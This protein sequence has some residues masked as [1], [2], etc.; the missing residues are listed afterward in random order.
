MHQL[1]SLGVSKAVN[2][3][4]E[5]DPD[6][7]MTFLNTVSSWMMLFI[8]LAIFWFA[9]AI[10][11]LVR[12]WMVQTSIFAM[13]EDLKDIKEILKD[14]NV[15]IKSVRTEQAVRNEHSLDPTGK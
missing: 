12:W 15:S 3:S 13:Q 4:S 5:V 6:S 10:A 11:F 1:I 7:F 14:N 2:G 8:I 9:L